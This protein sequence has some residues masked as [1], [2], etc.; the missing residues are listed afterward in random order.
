MKVNHEHVFK[1]PVVT[2]ALPVGPDLTYFP[3][4]FDLDLPSDS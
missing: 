4:L 1:L 2:E 3:N